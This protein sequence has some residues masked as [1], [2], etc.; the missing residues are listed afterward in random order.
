MVKLRD[1]IQVSPEEMRAAYC[2]AL[3]EEARKN[4]KIVALDCDL[5]TTCGT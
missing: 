2:G 3:M 4:D 5:S 1:V